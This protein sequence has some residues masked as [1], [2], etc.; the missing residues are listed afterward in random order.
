M[1]YRTIYD[2]LTSTDSQAEYTE[3]HHIIPKCMGGTNDKSNLVKLT[4]REHYIAHKLLT[5]IYPNS[6]KLLLAH[7]MMTVG[8]TVS[9]IQYEDAKKSRSLAM[10]LNNPVHKMSREEVDNMM[11]ALRSYNLGD[12]N[13]M[14]RSPELREMHS[15]RMKV[16]NPMTLHPERNHTAKPIIVTYED[17]TEE[18]YSYAKEFSDT[19][20][21]P[22]ATVK[23]IMRKKKGSKKHKILSVVQ[24]EA[25]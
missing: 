23:L 21:I 12:N 7:S 5:K 24:C 17:G 14:R 4:A 20:N 6:P 15:Q 11:D 18:H 25:S 8:R 1:D 2:S 10:K 22:Y 19:K 16:S 9:S 3:K 13:I